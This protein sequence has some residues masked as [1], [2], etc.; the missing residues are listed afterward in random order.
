MARPKKDAPVDLGRKHDLT[1][2]LIERAQCPPGLRQ[3]F[4]RDAQVAG[5]RV[6]LA[7]TG[8]KTFVF[9]SKV[10]GRTLRRSIGAVGD[11]PIT[12]ARIEA[13]KLAALIDQG[14]DPRQLAADAARAAAEAA[15]E[16]AR[17][18]AEVEAE[19]RAA[20]VTVGAAW[21]RYVEARRT[22]WS[23]RTLADHESMVLPGGVPKR[24]PA[25]A[26]T[27][28][29]ALHPLLGL[30]L[31][32]L[33]AAALERWASTEAQTRACR[34]RLALRLLKAFLR[35]CANEP[36]LGRFVQPSALAARAAREAAGVP[37]RRDDVLAREQLPAWF[38]AVRALSGRTHAAYLQ[39]LLLTGARPGEIAVMRWR[40]VDATWR[41]ITLRDKAQ[42]SRTIPLTPGVAELLAK[43]PRVN[44]WVF[45]ASRVVSLSPALIARRD[46]KHA[47]RGTEAPIGPVMETSRSGRLAD[48][49]YAHNRALA[50]AGLPHLTLHGLR[51]SFATLSEWI[52]VPVG[53]VAQI[54]GHAP[55]A[56]AERHYVRRPIDLLRVHHEHI[57]R[58]ILDA[59]GIAAAPVDRGPRL[60]L[61]FSRK[62]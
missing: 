48:P 58:W 46:R 34:V 55:S 39:V 35:W 37:A 18:A 12:N 59:G 17:V 56:I 8:A 22:R 26:V 61:T 51:R 9:E 20:A 57:E 62:D 43:L 4:L 30:R 52:E 42:G 50:A 14:L 19:A 53:V 40:D 54:M 32:D 27:K 60:P 45:A 31:A 16:A 25:G 2:G 3:A 6:R 10:A 24:R 44:E 36:D 15:A 23:A 11:W 21:A 7:P 29:G 38:A 5:L 1:V 13:R 33:D 49:R 47:A 28:P 41:T